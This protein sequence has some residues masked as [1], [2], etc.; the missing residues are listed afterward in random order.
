MQQK[1]NHSTVVHA[2]SQRPCDG[3]IQVVGPYDGLLRDV[4]TLWRILLHGV[5]LGP[6]RRHS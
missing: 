3:T 4:E 5:P 6:D 2:Q 1:R